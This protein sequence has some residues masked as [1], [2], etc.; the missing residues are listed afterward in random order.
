MAEMHT[1][2]QFLTSSSRSNVFPSSPMHTT[3]QFLSGFPEN[4]TVRFPSASLKTFR[5]D[6]ND[7]LTEHA[8]TTT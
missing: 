7:I 3:S 4:E 2:A 6:E 1:T 8:E 5:D